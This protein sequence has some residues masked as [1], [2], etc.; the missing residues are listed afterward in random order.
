[1]AKSKI[2]PKV[3]TY[4]SN[5]KKW[6]EETQALRMVLIDCG[7]SEDIK[8]GK[9]CYSFDESN[10]VI[11][12]G[13]KDYF[14]LLFFKG[15]LL[16]DANGVLVKMGENTN[17]GR[18][19]RFADV[20]E[21]RKMKPIIKA[22]IQEAIEL[23]KAGVRVTLKKTSEYTI[24]NE[25]QNKLNEMP[26]LQKAFDTLTP[27]RQKAYIFF[28]SQPKQSKTRESR[29]EKCIPQILEGKGLNDL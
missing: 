8:W 15:M 25:L 17:V 12:Q 1:M 23:E 27:G 18:Q 9:P 21:I 24:P 7:L 4:I 2:N 14:A 29:I 20:K 11:I 22:Y 10:I 5:A 13:F 3:D 16:K 19:M 28:F 26:A 6:Q